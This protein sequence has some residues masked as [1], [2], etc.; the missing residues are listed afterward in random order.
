MEYQELAMPPS[1]PPNVGFEEMSN[2]NFA[3]QLNAVA[4]ADGNDHTATE[5]LDTLNNQHL[6]QGIP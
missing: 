4:G 6:F 1:L 3:S 2:T 5:H